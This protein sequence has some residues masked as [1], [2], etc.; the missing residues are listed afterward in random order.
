MCLG[1]QPFLHVRSRTTRFRSYRCD[2]RCRGRGPRRRSRPPP[3]P[4]SP[5]QEQGV[6]STPGPA[7]Q[8]APSPFLPMGPPPPAAAAACLAI[9]NAVGASTMCAVRGVR[10][11]R[12]ASSSGTAGVDFLPG[13][14]QGGGHG[15]FRG[16][17]E[18]WLR[19]IDLYAWSCCY[20]GAAR[21]RAG[22]VQ[23]WARRKPD[24]AVHGFDVGPRCC[25]RSHM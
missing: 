6:G 12:S 16:R 7:A 20:A 17:V 4:N 24:A 1:E 22:Q 14:V 21:V 9:S 8:H 10:S 11:S 3:S 25:S 15:G 23:G 2:C 18:I 19:A 13:S 5:Q